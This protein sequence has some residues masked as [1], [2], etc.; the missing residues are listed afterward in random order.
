MGE[1]TQR[2][3]AG[4][5]TREE[6]GSVRSD[7]PIPLILGDVTDG[8]TI[9]DRTGRLIYAN[10][11]AARTSG[12]PSVEAMLAAPPGDFL[13]RF[14]LL[15][16]QNRP[17]SPDRL[18]GRLALQGE[19]GSEA[20]LRARDRKSGEEQWSIVKA[21]P[22]LDEDGSVRLVINIFKDVTEQKR[23]EER[24]RES[25]ER[26]RAMADT[27]PVMIWMAEADTLCTFFNHAW[28]DF[29]GRTMEE[30]LGIGWTEGV[31]PEDHQLCM[32]TYLTAFQLRESFRMEYRLR[33]ADGEYRWVLDVG[34]PR[35]TH[36]GEFAGYIGSALDITERKRAEE[37]I[38][39]LLDASTLLA[40][41]LDYGARLAALAQFVVPHL[42]DWCA[43][44]IVQDTGSPL[45]LAVAH[46]DPAK[47]EWARTLQQR[48]PSDPDAETGLPQV[49]RSGRSEFYPR[50][51]DEMLAAAARD[52]EHL[53]ILRGLGFRSAII[54]P[55][56][57]R[58]RILGA[59]TL[60]TSE[61]GRYY[62]DKD[63]AL[64]EELARRAATAIDNA[65][66]F[67]E[68][69]EAREQIELQAHEL[70]EVAAELEAANEE[71]IARTAEAER[72]NRAKSEFLAMMSHEL[73]T[74]LNAIAGYVDLLDLEIHGPL[75][76]SQHEDLR[77]IQLSQHHL[78]G[79]IND[80]LNFA[81]LEAGH[82]QCAIEELALDDALG[83]LHPLIE[84]QLRA[85]GLQYEYRGGDRSVTTRVDPEKLRQILL[86][87]LSNAV[88]F[89][90]AGG[91]ITLDW[92]ARE[93][94]VE[95]RVRDTGRGIPESDLQA[96]FEP[97]YQVDSALTRDVSGVGLGLAISRDL[98]RAMFGELRA[99]ST[100]GQGST[101]FLSLPRGVSL[102]RRS[103][104]APDAR[105]G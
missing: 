22:V 62:D 91:R 6:S 19:P 24:L 55:L 47:V 97:F 70:E 87:L 27:A 72:A 92:E 75:T 96:I 49:L 20:T 83:F 82:V 17:L 52:A 35:F 45:R 5:R 61:S 78:L 88:K 46:Q 7:A 54:A 14:E 73:R 21:L 59:L 74:P 60:V 79:I 1:A 32:D 2:A 4:Q 64:A 99:E 101:F 29:T 68:V 8:I 100:P 94:E 25:E 30:E 80:V 58:G 13:H 56:A 105:N 67:N 18:P 103:S 98:A 3:E 84:P 31:H 33:A 57:T 90:P 95:V 66:L 41:S 9:Q 11:S 42:A 77:K 12:Y 86:N 38:R 26:F 89:T 37:G 36:T 63:L 15:D 10:T 39:F 16:E 40:E 102:G 50:I 104:L 85:K 51:P 23:T 69:S 34:V 53:A 81:K 65:R 76:T 48:Y 43:V 28:L 44:D 93:S 71:L